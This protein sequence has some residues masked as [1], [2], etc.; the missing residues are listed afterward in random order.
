M[1]KTYPIIFVCIVIFLSVV[2]CHCL[3]RRTTHAERDPLACAVV[4]TQRQKQEGLKL[5]MFADIA[6]KY[7]EAGGKDEAL[8]LLSQAYQLA[9]NV[10]HLPSRPLYLSDV[11]L[12]YAKVGE[13]GKASQILSQAVKA[14]KAVRKPHPSDWLAII[15]MRYAEIGEYDQAIR[16]FK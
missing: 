5:R 8:K 3:A 7:A 2:L 10:K 11:A 14:T 1:N 6:V 15:A 12:R 9:N 16:V 4:I 13:K